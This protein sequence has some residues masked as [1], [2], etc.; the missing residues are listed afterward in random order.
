MM[1]CKKDGGTCGY[2]GMCD[3][4]GEAG[5]SAVELV[6]SKP[7]VDR[8]CERFEPDGEII[9]TLEDGHVERFWLPGLADEEYIERARYL[10]DNA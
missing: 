9:V 10:R 6:V 5:L 4:C 2:G 1:K 7:T 3:E 8:T